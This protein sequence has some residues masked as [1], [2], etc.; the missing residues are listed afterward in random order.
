LLAECVG[1]LQEVQEAVR[2]RLDGNAEADYSTPLAL[3]SGALGIA[4]QG[5]VAALTE[6][7]GRALNAA[8]A[9]PP[10][11]IEQVPQLESLT[12][13]V[14]ALELYLAG[15]RDEQANSLRFL[16]VMHDRLD[17][18][19]EASASGDSVPATTIELPSVAAE[20]VP[21]AAPTQEDAKPAT[22][23]VTIDPAMLGIFLEEFD[24]VKDQL[25]QRLQQWLQDSS[26][27]RAM[28]ELRRGFHTL[29]GSGRMVGAEE[30]GDFAWVFEDLFNHFIDGKLQVSEALFEAA[31]LGV[32][33]L[34]DLRAR[35][36]GEHARLDDTGI[37][38]LK[39]FARQLA[40]GNEPDP[41]ELSELV[42]GTPEEVPAPETT[43]TQAA[44]ADLPKPAL[45]ELLGSGAPDPTLK[46]LMIGEIRSYLADLENF[47]AAL[48]AG[49]NQPVNPNL[50][51]AVHTLAGTLSMAPLGQEAEVARALEHYLDNR[52]NS[53]REVT[54]A[55]TFCMQCCLHRFHQR[56]SVLEDDQAVT[57]PLDDEQLLRELAEL[58]ATEDSA[59]TATGASPAERSAEAEAAAVEE[60]PELAAPAPVS[61]EP[62]TE[63]SGPLEIEDKGI[64]SIFLEE[65]TEVLERCDT[66]L[67]TWRDK[68]SDRKLVQNL[69]RE[70]HTFK[71]G[72]RMA[73]LEGLGELSHSMETLLEHIA[74]NRVEATVAAVQALEE[75]CDSLNR[76]VEQ[77]QSGRMPDVE[78][79]V[80]ALR[81]PQA[82]PDQETSVVAEA[83]MPLHTRDSEAVGAEPIQADA[84]QDAPGER[85][86][87]ETGA[88]SE[89][90]ASEPLPHVEEPKA[91]P[92]AR[93]AERAKPAF[94]TESTREFREIEDRPAADDAAPGAQIRVAA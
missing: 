57:Y 92:R 22:A 29:K 59:A 19:P 67:N 49:S 54:D 40:E 4:S 93:P 33:A 35:M 53:D 8:L 85:V 46:R 41:A 88:A 38:T 50:V 58:A 63:D 30:V 87:P 55:A 3:I 94:G 47:V 76:F 45:E 24:S 2:Q 68:L 86:E 25:E 78:K 69:Q 43:Q 56:L 9:D 13:A 18:I 42:L 15:C 91:K 34:G 81:M 23:A 71:G 61:E 75:G 84:G 80:K 66:L 90:P 5:E 72:A 26:D 31:R 6:K 14:A 12:D 37:R 64:L 82:A 11:S 21:P 1:S 51:R 89:P 70:I 52:L 36:L 28:A 73:G 7:L 17:G 83:P 79:K 32:E 20:V 27:A 10:E 77:L 44:A 65:A 60:T 16:Q 48:A 39:G 62:A 74:A